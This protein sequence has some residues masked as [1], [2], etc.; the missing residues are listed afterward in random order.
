[1]HKNNL[2]PCPV[3]CHPA[4][5]K[6]AFP[7]SYTICPQCDWEDDQW[8][9]E[10]PTKSGGANQVSLRQAQLYFK[11]FETIYPTTT[12]KIYIVMEKLH[13]TSWQYQGHQGYRIS[14]WA[15]NKDVFVIEDGHGHSLY[16]RELSQEDMID[17]LHK[18]PNKA[19][20]EWSCSE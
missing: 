8:Q 10:Y 11:R 14:I 19:L 1:M 15:H 9:L 6:E 4:F 18:N 20:F 5:E 16:K 12:Q 13:K 2:N 17:Y 3:C 7:G